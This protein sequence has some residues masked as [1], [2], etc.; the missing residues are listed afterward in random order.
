MVHAV[1]DILARIVDHKRVELS[2]NV[3]RRGELERRAADRTDHRDFR[4]GLVSKK[5]AIIAEIKQASPSRGTLST[6]FDP[7]SI[8][9]DY[10][11]GGAAALSVLT[12]AKFF[13][14]S[15]DDLAQAREAVKIPV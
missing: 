11:S 2:Q 14:G 15:L 8:A 12:D 1:P 7:A 13:Q 9:R 10:G 4:A 3:S 6:D 5:P